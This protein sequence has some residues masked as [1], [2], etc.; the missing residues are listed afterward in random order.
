MTR[1]FTD[2]FATINAIEGYSYLLL[3]FIAMPLKYALGFPLAVKVVGMA[4]GVLF[5]IFCYYLYKATRETKW[6]YALA[7]LF[8]AASLVPF[9]SFYNK[10]IIS[11]FQK[12]RG[13]KV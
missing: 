5:M 4:H 6:S 12:Q 8:F 10:G 3:V 11:V 9:G 13:Q 1:H 7:T 2:K